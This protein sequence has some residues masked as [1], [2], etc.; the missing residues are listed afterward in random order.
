MT[1]KPKEGIIQIVAVQR[2]IDG[3][4]LIYGLSNFGKLYRLE[5]GEWRLAAA[6]LD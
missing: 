2:T 4:A 1:I 6:E 5:N 3:T